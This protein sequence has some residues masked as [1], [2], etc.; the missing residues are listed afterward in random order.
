M[1][2]HTETTDN[3]Q[4]V[5]IT[6]P[7]I[8]EVKRLMEQEKDEKLYL[9]LGVAAGGCSGMSYSMAFD[10]EKSDNDSL[11]DYDGLQVLIDNRAMTYLHGCVLDF[12]GGM[13]GGGFHFENPNARRSCGC[14]TSF[15]C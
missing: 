6:P 7:A 13:L 5:T 15:S 14:G 12:K 10:T 1:T 2:E 8:A 11:F 9:R 3:T 4:T